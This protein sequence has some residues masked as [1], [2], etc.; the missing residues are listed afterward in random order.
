MLE[1]YIAGI[2]YT[3]I[4]L[5]IGYLYARD[6]VQHTGWLGPRDVYVGFCATAGTIGWPILLIIY[7]VTLFFGVI[8]QSI[9]MRARR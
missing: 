7:G 2:I 4:G 8:S 1:G 5:P 6:Q 3:L 9:R